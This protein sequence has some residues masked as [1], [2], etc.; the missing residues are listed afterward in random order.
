MQPQARPVGGGLGPRPQA[1]LVGLR[2][3]ADN[4][5]LQKARAQALLEASVADIDKGM[6][7]EYMERLVQA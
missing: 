7:E 4:L 6:V 2:V 1:D 3:R 5:T